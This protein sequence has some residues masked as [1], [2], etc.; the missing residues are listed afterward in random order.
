MGATLSD[1]G[2]EMRLGWRLT[3]GAGDGP[4]SSEL[5]FEATRRESANDETPLE[6]G[7]GLQL[8]ARF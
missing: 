2:R 5:S 4:G 3:G 7:V 1:T 6:H 8:T